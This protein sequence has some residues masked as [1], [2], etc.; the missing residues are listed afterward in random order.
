[1]KLLVGCGVIFVKSL[2]TIAALQSFKI[3]NV[4]L[5]SPL[6]LYL[7]DV[8]ISLFTRL[9]LSCVAEYENQVSFPIAAEP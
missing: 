6:Q 3:W 2:V 7:V 8:V 1:M 5:L 4:V 9:K